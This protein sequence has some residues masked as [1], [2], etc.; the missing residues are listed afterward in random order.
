MTYPLLH[1]CFLDTWVEEPGCCAY[2]LN[3]YLI[4]AVFKS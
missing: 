2:A 1:V 3:K 4:I